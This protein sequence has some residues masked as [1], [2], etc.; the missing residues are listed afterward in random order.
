M[1][2]K[3][4]LFNILSQAQKEKVGDDFISYIYSNYILSKSNR[5]RSPLSVQLELSPVCNFKCG[6]CYVRKTYSEVES[7]GNTIIGFR[8]WAY[9]IDECIK[10]GVNNVTFTG[11]ECTLHPDFKKIY[12]Y[13]YKK[14][15]LISLITNAS[16]ITE[17]IFLLFEKYP[18]FRISITLYGMSYETYDK[19]CGNGSAFHIVIS[20]I[21]RL[22]E[23]GF[24][25]TL[26]YTA[27][28]TNFCDMEIAMAY[29][30]EKKIPIFPTDALICSGRC[31]SKILEKELIEHREFKEMQLKHFSKVN[32]S[33]YEDM[34]DLFLTHY[35]EPIRHN[36][37]GLFCSA[38]KSAIFINWQGFMIPCVN[39]EIVKFDPRK[40][41]F[42]ECWKRLMAWTDDVPLL[43]ECEGCIFFKKCH[44][45]FAYHYGDMGEF[46]KV[47]PRFC[48]KVLYPEAAAKMQ[49]EYDRRQAEK[50]NQETN[51]ATVQGDLS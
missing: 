36:N 35:S 40:L 37:K 18:P 10:L 27:V 50:A 2:N 30:R 15:L 4:S 48:F 13:A 34:L 39:F 38:G 32:N 45:C 47:S 14:D 23:R 16:C 33:S 8:E 49:A 29:A 3:N 24:S 42:E 17:D 26:N 1:E 19:T 9:Y 46:G 43:E 12:E 5:N 44:R 7:E 31:N 22:L 20:N 11:G 25:V 28:K 41:G 51:N 6:F 21:E